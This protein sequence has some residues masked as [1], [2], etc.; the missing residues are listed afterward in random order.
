MR[1][2]VFSIVL[3]L[4]VLAALELAARL[5]TEPEATGVLIHRPVL[6][7]YPGI[8]NPEEIFSEVTPDTLEWAPYEHWT[9]RPNLRGRFFRTN[10]LGLRGEKTTIEK[11]A[12][13]FRIA[14]LGG[15]AAWGLGATSD[16]NTFCGQLQ[17]CLRQ[18]HPKRDIEVLNA[19]Q[20]GYVSA[21][22]L[23]YFQRVIWR[24]QPD[25]VL[26]FDGYNDI[27]ADFMNPESGWPQHAAVLKARYE[28]SWKPLPAS[29]DLAALLRRSRLLAGMAD[30]WRD[31]HPAPRSAEIIRPETTARTYVRNIIALARIA[32]PAPVWVALQPSVATTAKP[33]TS[34]E[35]QIVQVKETH[36]SGYRQ[37]VRKTYRAMADAIGD[38]DFPLIPLQDALGTEPKLLFADECHFGDEAAKRIAKR[39][40]A[41]LSEIF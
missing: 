31:K 10:S 14:V 16:E 20:I 4:G 18:Q 32:A 11:P 37:R 1:K 25:V 3:A 30:L 2:L 7:L 22:E 39:I 33:L 23:I 17:A 12:G 24:M 5:F 29:Y 34:E 19:A 15:S 41:G 26:L 38:A 40:A 35:Q 21:Q 9:M 13:R 28:A 8:E 6:K 27:N 36:V